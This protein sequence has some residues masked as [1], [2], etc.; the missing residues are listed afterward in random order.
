MTNVNKCFNFRWSFCNSDDDEDRA[1]EIKQIDKAD[2]NKQTTTETKEYAK[3]QPKAERKQPETAAEEV[4]PKPT[5]N[6][7]NAP[8]E[9]TAAPNAN[10]VEVEPGEEEVADGEWEYYYEDVVETKAEKVEK[11]EEVKPDPAK[12]D[13]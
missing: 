1:E 9:N 5:K 4:A 10:G 7:A 11:E 8:I 13:K 3:V 6:A 12:V 2:V